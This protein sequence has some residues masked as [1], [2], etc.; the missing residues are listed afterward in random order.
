VST[1]TIIRQAEFWSRQTVE[2]DQERYY[3]FGDNEG[4]V[5]MGGQACI[6]GLDNAFGIPTKKSVSEFWSDDNLKANKKAIEEAIA[7]IPT[8]KPWVISQDGLGTGLSELPARAPRTYQYLVGRITEMEC[9]GYALPEGKVLVLRTCSFARTGQHSDATHFVYPERGF[10]ACADFNKKK[11]CGGGLHGCIW[12]SGSVW[13]SRAMFQVLEVEETGIVDLGDKCKFES[14]VVLYT[15]YS[16]FATDLIAQFAPVGVMIHYRH[17]SGGNRSHISGGNRSHISGGNRSHISGG[18]GSHIS[19][20]YGSHISG[21]YGSHISGGEKTVAISKTDGR[22]RASDGSCLMMAVWEDGR[23]R[24]YAA[25][26][27]EATPEGLMIEPDVFY[28]VKDGTW[29]K[30]ANQEEVRKAQMP[31]LPEPVEEVK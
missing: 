24:G 4:G 5:G 18:Y 6:R 13:D 21:G 3:I 15:G 16:K 19:G 31:E 27:G 30:A 11:V 7:K 12:G 20:G 10:V 17:I 23:Y 28:T 1:P 26:V 14:A 22:V 2:A 8:D 25:N 9:A 29:Q